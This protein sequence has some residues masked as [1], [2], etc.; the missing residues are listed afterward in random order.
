MWHQ[1]QRIPT[2]FLW[3][4]RGGE[5]FIE[6]R[7]G[8]LGDYG[9]ASWDFTLVEGPDQSESRGT[10]PGSAPTFDYG[11]V[12]VNGP[13][14]TEIRGTLSDS[15]P[16]FAWLLAWI[17]G[18]DQSETRGT[19]GGDSPAFAWEQLWIFAPDQIES[20]GTISAEPSFANG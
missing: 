5:T 2:P 12:N 10:L 6:E 18:P 3:V 15:A 11:D 8:H 20:R 14:Q 7:M 19:V 9:S 13:P 4:S 1:I 16:S 17:Y